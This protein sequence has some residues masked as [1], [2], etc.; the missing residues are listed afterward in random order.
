MKDRSTSRET[1]LWKD[2]VK[3]MEVKPMLALPDELE[4]TGI[5][6]RDEGL[7]I[8][9]VSKQ[10]RACCPLC[11]TE[12]SRL[13]SRY[14]RAVADLPCGGQQVRL[15]VG[16]RRYFCDVPT[17]QRKIFA[18]RLTPFV[19][20]RARVTQRLYQIVQIIGL[21]TGGRLGVRVTDRLQIQT[22]RHTILRRI[23]ALPHE[24]VGEVRQIGIDDFSFR[25]GRKFGTIVVDLQTHKVLDV[26]PDRTAETSAAW[27]ST[28]P[29][30]ELVSRDRG[31]DYA[32]AA[33]KAI[34]GATQTADRFHLLKNLGEA[35]EGVL[36]RHLAAQRRRQTETARAAPLLA[37][38]AQEPPN[39]LPKN[40]AL[41]Q[42]KREA[43]LAQYQQVVAL[44]EQGF[45]QPAIASQVG[46]SHA[47]VSRWLSNGTFPEQKPRPRSASADPYLPQLVE[48]W[49]EGLQTVAELHR[50]LVANGYSHQY[51]SVYRRLARSFPEAQKKRCTRSVPS[52]QKKQE[53]TDQLPQPH[54]LARKAVFLF[55]RR[56][57]EL[58]ADEQETLAW[59]RSLHAEVN[60]AYELIQQ[61]AQMLRTRTAEQLDGWLSRVRASQIR[62]LQGFVAGVIRDKAAVV[63][64]LTL[65]QNNG[66]AEGKINKLKLIKRMGYGRAGF[67]LLRQRVLHAL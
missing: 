36:S 10:L 55:L 48:Q 43:R 12:A 44:R 32:A 4:V 31:G 26:L 59:L 2:H 51:N 27:M 23:L 1:L 60:L 50:D 46:I 54:V 16:V 24:P 56:P 58:E 13:H 45:S 42:A 21:A 52:G 57:E 39:V 33:R 6:M 5:E 62:E 20:P 61:F 34:P 22:S 15:L 65:P 37:S 19:E 28:H 8:T 41:S 67:P 47:T 3:S 49:K 29:E 38:Q 63:A 53:A 25:R 30:I 66:L 17:C 9:V 18:E 14:T 11:S 40:V 35:L 64:G 7:T